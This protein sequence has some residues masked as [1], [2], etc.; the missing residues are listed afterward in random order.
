M[1]LDM[2]REIQAF[3]SVA[4]KRS[5]VAAARALGRSPSAV[6][7]AVQTLEDNA[8]SKLLNR[9]ANAVTCREASSR[10]RNK[11]PPAR[12][13][14]TRFSQLQPVDVDAIKGAKQRWFLPRASATQTG[15]IVSSQRHRAPA[16]HSSA[17]LGQ[18]GYL[19]QRAWRAPRV[20]PPPPQFFD[21]PSTRMILIGRSLPSRSG[22]L[23]QAPSPRP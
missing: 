8:G 10:W 4:H 5:F 9:N 2:L 12:P 13:R 1:A 16:W 17:G 20:R 22:Q 15:Q 19:P 21:G 18:R 14:R 3:V 7:R 23:M 11:G 6:T